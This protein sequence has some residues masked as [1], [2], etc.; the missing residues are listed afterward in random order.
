MLTLNNKKAKGTTAGF[1]LEQRRESLQYS[2][3]VDE[4][5]GTDPGHTCTSR[6]ESIFHTSDQVPLD[7][8]ISN[9]WKESTCRAAIPFIS[10]RNLAHIQLVYGIFATQRRPHSAIIRWIKPTRQHQDSPSPTSC[11]TA[12]S[13]RLDDDVKLTRLF[14]STVTP[15]RIPV[16]VSQSP[17]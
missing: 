15:F 3:G 14:L 13:I 4:G 10:S 8:T 11:Q 9:D 6:S 2:S 7:L 12:S 16:P 17:G 5:V 1:R